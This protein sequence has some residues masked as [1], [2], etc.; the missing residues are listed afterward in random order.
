MESS[1]EMFAGMML[2]LA[3]ITITLF[4]SSYPVPSITTSPASIM[5]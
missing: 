2:S 3:S 1:M 4:T 5:L